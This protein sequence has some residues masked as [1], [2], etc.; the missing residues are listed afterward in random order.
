[1]VRIRETWAS[2]SADER[3]RVRK[4]IAKYPNKERAQ[5][6]KEILNKYHDAKLAPN[7]PLQDRDVTSQLAADLAQVGNRSSSASKSRT[8]K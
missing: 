7:V 4:I 1:M 3:G 6:L 8:T 2:F 5:Q